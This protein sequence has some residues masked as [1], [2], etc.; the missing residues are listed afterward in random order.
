MLHAD[1]AFGIYDLQQNTQVAMTAPRA[2]RVLTTTRLVPAV[3][4]AFASAAAGYAHFSPSHARLAIAAGALAGAAILLEAGHAWLQKRREAKQRVRE[5][6]VQ[7]T[8]AFAEDGASLDRIV[9]GG[10]ARFDLRTK[11]DTFI[12]AKHARGLKTVQPRLMAAIK[13]GL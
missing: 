7:Q 11:K 6:V 5:V 4:A 9:P 2:K 1:G 10:I 13:R 8:V 12:A 3:S